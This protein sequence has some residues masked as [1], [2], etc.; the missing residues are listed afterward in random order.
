MEQKT[1]DAIKRSNENWAKRD[2]AEM[3]R[4]QQKK[5]KSAQ[6]LYWVNIR[7]VV[8]DNLVK[9]TTKASYK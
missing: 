5:N 4:K 9:I 1:I 7:D 3:K 8:D 6:S 2:Y